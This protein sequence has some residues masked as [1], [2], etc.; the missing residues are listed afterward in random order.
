MAGYEKKT[1]SV[2]STHL[3]RQAARQKMEAGEL[4]SAEWYLRRALHVAE[5]QYGKYHGETGMVLL[6]LSQLYER[7]GR[8]LEKLRVERRIDEI[9]QTYTCADAC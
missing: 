1:E 7:S 8:T 3:Y 9:V 6:D 5:H 4:E 2:S